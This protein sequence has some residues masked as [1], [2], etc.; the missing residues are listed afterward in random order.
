MKTGVKN[1][2]KITGPPYKSFEQEGNLLSRGWMILY[3]SWVIILK[4]NH[5][6]K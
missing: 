3:G 4:Y 1:K 5:V 6:L 2:A